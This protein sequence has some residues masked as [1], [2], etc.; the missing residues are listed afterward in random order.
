MNLGLVGGKQ[1][2]PLMNHIIELL[3]DHN[4]LTKL[5]NGPCSPKAEELPFV[6]IN[7]EWIDAK[8]SALVTDGFRKLLPE[9]VPYLSVVLVERNPNTL[10]DGVC[11]DDNAN[12]QR[13]I[14]VTVIPDAEY[15]FNYSYPLIHTLWMVELGCWETARATL[16]ACR[17]DMEVRLVTEP[18]PP[19]LNNARMEWVSLYLGRKPYEGYLKLSD[20][21]PENDPDGLDCDVHLLRV[22]EM[23]SDPL[24]QRLL[25]AYDADH[26]ET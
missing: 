12:R 5:L 23:D 13:Y 20:Q 10:Y 22:R 11:V 4:Y 6:P 18:K 7:P 25:C 26:P 8:A 2:G 16:A 3:M 9:D 14:V 15:P 19:I 17:K 21:R 24:L 1:K